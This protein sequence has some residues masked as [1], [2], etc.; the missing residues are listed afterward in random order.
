MKR[1]RKKKKILKSKFFQ[2]LTDP[3]IMTKLQNQ[4]KV[5]KIKGGSLIRAQYDNDPNSMT[6]FKIQYP[7]TKTLKKI[8]KTKTPKKIVQKYKRS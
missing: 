3:D 5:Q 6:E 4:K 1:E 7:K 2:K 8:K